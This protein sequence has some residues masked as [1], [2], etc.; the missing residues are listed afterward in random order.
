MEMMELEGSGRRRIRLRRK[1]GDCEKGL[2]EEMPQRHSAVPSV[3][4]LF[5]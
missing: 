4:R 2:Q 5:K 1:S 3:G